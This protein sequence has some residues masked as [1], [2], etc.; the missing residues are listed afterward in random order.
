MGHGK[1]IYHYA[2]GHKESGNKALKSATRSTVGVAGAAGGFVV[3]SGP[4]FVAGYMGGVA[5]ADGA[6]SGEPF[7][8]SRSLL[9]TIFSSYRRRRRLSFQATKPPSASE[10][11][12]LARFESEVFIS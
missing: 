4:G 6:I 12:M 1:A 8:V 10:D 5:V 7:E 9:P 11:L 3:G 2:R